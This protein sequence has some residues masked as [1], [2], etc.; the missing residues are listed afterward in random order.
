VRLTPGAGADRL[1][2][3][4]DDVLH[5]RV[6]ARPVDGAANEALITVLA[7]TLR[8]PRG[9]IRIAAGQRS[10]RKL[11]ELDGVTRESVEAAARKADV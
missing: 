7:S 2:R 4:T 5:V 10:R 3:F 6:A 8:I 1:D 9:A 11:V